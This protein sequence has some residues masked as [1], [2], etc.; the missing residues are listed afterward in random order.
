MAAN[1]DASIQFPNSFVLSISSYY[2]AFPLILGKH[3]KCFSSACV[4]EGKVFT[5]FQDFLLIQTAFWSE[6]CQ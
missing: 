2:M 6:P 4:N 5:P 1:G 3:S